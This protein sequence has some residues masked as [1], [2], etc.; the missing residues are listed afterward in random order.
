VR[1]IQS[2]DRPPNTT[3]GCISRQRPSTAR[4]EL[5][6]HGCCIVRKEAESGRRTKCCSVMTPPSK[7]CC[8]ASRRHFREPNWCW[9]HVVVAHDGYISRKRAGS[10]PRERRCGISKFAHVASPVLLLL[11]STAHT[12]YRSITI[13]RRIERIAGS[14][15]ARIRDSSGWMQCWHHDF[16]IC[17]G[18]PALHPNTQQL[19]SLTCQLSKIVP[20][21]TLT[22]LLDSRA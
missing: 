20:S 15:L 4:N 10:P 8:S 9:E 13:Y 12:D 1:F 5:T 3:Q 16:N 6:T 7:R 17:C 2:P 18:Q 19:V 11:L 21:R 22:S 14:S